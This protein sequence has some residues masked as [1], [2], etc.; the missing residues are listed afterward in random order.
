[1]PARPG[2][3]KKILDPGPARPVRKARRPGPARLK[4]L[5]ARARPDPPHKIFRPALNRQKKIS[6]QY[7]RVVD[8]YFKRKD[9][10]LLENG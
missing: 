5:L 8:L 7:F 10:V 9:K 6:S 1:M 2:P 3:S 4:N